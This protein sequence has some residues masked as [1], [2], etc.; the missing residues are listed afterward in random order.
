MSSKITEMLLSE[1]NGIERVDDIS[2][3]IR[4]RK[5]RTFIAAEA[6]IYSAAIVESAVSVWRRDDQNT[7]LLPIVTTKP[8]RERQEV[9]S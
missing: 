6:A 7:G 2:K 9:G 4:R 8:V 1:S 5:M 3:W